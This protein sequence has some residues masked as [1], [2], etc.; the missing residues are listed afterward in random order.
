MLT[1]KGILPVGIERDGKFHRE[2]EIRPALVR[3][4]IE[5]S[6]ENDALQ[7]LNR[8][9]VGVALTA[10][11]LIRIGDISPVLPADLL[12]AL[13][14]DLEEISSAKERLEK[15]L[16]SFHAEA[17]KKAGTA[18]AVSEAAKGNTETDSDSSKD[19]VSTGSDS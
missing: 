18:D 2:F 13:D 6:K 4:A 1:E 14:I 7:L 15:R 12:N 17:D 9:F 5:I 11:E 3:D 16:R 10:K 19:S 8:A